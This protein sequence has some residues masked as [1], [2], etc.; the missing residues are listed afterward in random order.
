MVVCFTNFI[1]KL[2]AT[3]MLSYTVY[4]SITGA[5]LLGGLL[6]GAHMDVFPFDKF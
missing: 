3:I 5:L 1:Y 4:T 6:I 2:S